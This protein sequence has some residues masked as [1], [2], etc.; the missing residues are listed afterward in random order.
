MVKGFSLNLNQYRN[1]HFYK[2]NN[3]KIEYK[4]FMRSQIELLPELPAIRL[5][6]V[7]YPKTN[8]EFDISNVCSIVDKFFSD[9]LV[10]L[11]KLPDD[12]F[13]FISEVVYKFG[14][15]DKDNPRVEIIIETLESSI[16]TQ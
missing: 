1:A 2:L 12:N 15:K 3:A 6:Y 10:E 9:A 5:T 13:K 11:G 16:D 7:V 4:A 8:R 14:E